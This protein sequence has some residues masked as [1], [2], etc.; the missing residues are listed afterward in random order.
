[1]MTI[2]QNIEELAHKVRNE[3][4]GRDVREALATSIEATAEVAE[5]SRQ[6]AQQIIDGEFDEVELLTKLNELEQEY[7]TLSDKLQSGAFKTTGKN[8]LDMTALTSGYYVNYNHGRLTEVSGYSASDFIAIRPSETY[9]LS[10]QL[11]SV[12]TLE[13]FAFYDD[14]KT[15]ISGWEGGSSPYTFTTPTNARYIRLTIADSRNQGIQ[16]EQNEVMTEYEPYEYGLNISDFKKGQITAD[17]LSKELKDSL[18]PKNVISVKKDGSGDFD[19]LREAL[20]SITDASET[21]QYEVQVHEGS[22]DVFNDYTSTEIEDISFIGLIKP[23]W[24]SIF[25]IGDVEIKG[26]LTSSYSN[27]AMRRVSTLCTYGNGDLENI[28]VTAKN[29]RYAVHDDYVFPD[30]KRKAKKCKFIYYHDVDGYKI[31]YGAGSRSGMEFEFEDCKFITYSSDHAFSFH[32]NVN[33]LKRSKLKMKNCSFENSG[34][35]GT[36]LRLGSM[37]SGQKD[38]VELI[39]CRFSGS[40]KIFEEQSNGVGIDFEVTGYGNDKVPVY[41]IHSKANHQPTYDFQGETKKL[42]SAD[43]TVIP[44]GTPVRYNSSATVITSSG[45]T[46]L[47]MIGIALEDIQPSSS[48]IVRVN[49]FLHVADTPLTELSIGDKI[50]VKNGALAKVTSG[51]YIGTLVSTN[52]IKLKI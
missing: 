11:S 4:Y 22:Y 43:S 10:N 7:A 12:K 24:V 8:L 15:F 36:V 30:A 1:M 9:V 52:W 35:G 18:T 49:G 34:T 14:T 47:T 25:G 41:I 3:I 21:N 44:K 37:G 28:T 51:D 27:A 45:V 2:P 23:D 20:E 42:Y 16:L 26:E 31:A 40:I 32:N 29:L 13:Q 19:N 33:F 5:W 39:G 46:T 50:G 17:Y 6:V 38:K 48:G